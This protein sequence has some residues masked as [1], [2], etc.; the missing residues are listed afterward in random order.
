M[1]PVRR[2]DPIGESNDDRISL[3]VHFGPASDGAAI[4]VCILLFFP[5][6][7]QLRRT[8]PFLWWK[9]LGF[10]RE[11]DFANVSDAAQSQ[12]PPDRILINVLSATCHSSAFRPVCSVSIVPSSSICFFMFCFWSACGWVTKSHP[13]IYPV[14]TLSYSVTDPLYSTCSLPSVS[15][16]PLRPWPFPSVRQTAPDRNDV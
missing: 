12:F 11:P 1:S 16:F 10:A 2:T 4:H 5:Y 13:T 9:L 7:I 14:P 6:S 15:L 3:N 8:G